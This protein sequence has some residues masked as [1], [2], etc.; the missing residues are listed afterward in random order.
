MTEVSDWEA[1]PGRARVGVTGGREQ[2]KVAAGGGGC[3]NV[4]GEKT[5]TEK[6]AR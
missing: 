6:R 1:A 4:R 3:Y 5:L 2:R